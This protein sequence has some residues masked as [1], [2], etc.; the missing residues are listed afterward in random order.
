MKVYLDT[1]PLTTGHAIRGIGTYTKQLLQELE[2]NSEITVVQ[3]K[4]ESKTAD[5]VHYP[6]FDLFFD[7]LPV[8]FSKKTVVTIHD[9]IPLEFPEFYKPGIKGSLRF[10]KQ[11]LALRWVKAVITD[12]MYSKQKINEL[13]GV[14]NDKIT[15]V[16]L[17]ANS[18]FK[19]QP[20]AIIR[21]HKKEY[22]LPEKYIL[23]VGDINYNKNIPQLIKALKFLPEY[24]SLVC[25]GK[26]FT[27]QD[28][29]EWQWIS[30]QL[31]MSQVQ[32][33]V[34]FLT[35][36]PATE[37]QTLATLYS[38]AVAYVQPSLSEG[39]GLPVL[40][41][42]QCHCPVVSS[43]RGSLPEVGGAV[44]VYVEPVAEDIARGVEKIMALKPKDLKDLQE[45]GQK[46]AECFSWK[47]TAAETIAVY[48]KISKQ[49]F[50]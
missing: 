36:I 46:W 13:L 30:S 49:S 48:K 2:K 42:L 4:K 33:R 18:E 17:A 22:N 43:N 25:V 38:G 5:V 10:R 40:E 32:A 8:S 20:P 41:A 31:E 47:K 9:V 28:I 15:V 6:Y 19:P 50:K 12:S 39:F 26:N 1:S 27:E 14:A 35:D 29:P 23:Y 7:S 16:Y 3:E 37:V 34:R 44:S 45:S 11:K 24:L 21:E